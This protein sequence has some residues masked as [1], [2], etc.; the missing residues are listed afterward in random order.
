MNRRRKT[1]VAVSATLAVALAAGLGAAALLSLART[2]AEDRLDTA[3]GDLDGA[4]AAVDERLQVLGEQRERAVEVHE[5]ASRPAAVAEREPVE[6]LDAALVD[7]GE[8]ADAL[9]AE[10]EEAATVRDAHPAEPEAFWPWE[11]D[12]LSEPLETASAALAET[13]GQE[14]ADLDDLSDGAEAQMEAAERR[15]ETMR[16]RWRDEYPENPALGPNPGAGDGSGR[17]T[18]EGIVDDLAGAPVL[19]VDLGCPWHTACGIAWMSDG[20]VM[21]NSGTADEVWK[22]PFNRYI[23]A[24]E[25]G[26]AR[27]SQEWDDI[28]RDLGMSSDRQWD[29]NEQ[30]ADCFTEL[31]GYTD[32]IEFVYGCPGGSS[33]AMRVARYLVENQSADR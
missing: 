24:H 18:A 23:A 16:E 29:L 32:G 14:I 30:I 6:L 7:V 22:R 21:L 27:H 26:H 4:I 8:H 33:D 31:V 12:E 9:R 5:L 2:Q 11:L 20:T 17:E 19:W 13:M 10:Q 3:V 15:I 1:L 28:E 25:A